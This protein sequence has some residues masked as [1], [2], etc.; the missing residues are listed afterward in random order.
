MLRNNKNCSLIVFEEQK[1]EFICIEGGF[2][3]L[4]A[5]SPPTKRCERMLVHVGSYEKKMTLKNAS[6]LFA[7][8]KS[9]SSHTAPVCC[10]NSF[11]GSVRKWKSS[12]ELEKLIE[13]LSHFDNLSMDG[14]SFVESTAICLFCIFSFSS[15]L[16]FLST[17]I[18]E[19]RPGS[20]HNDSRALPEATLNFIKTHSLMDEN[21]PPYFGL[22]ILTRV[23]TQ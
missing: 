10:A 20:C 14:R 3:G 8:G 16:L 11:F 21:V 15:R 13:F 7:F 2:G 9:S 23:S 5:M 1:L 4:K 17:Q 22:P 12:R 19:P 18:P 6:C